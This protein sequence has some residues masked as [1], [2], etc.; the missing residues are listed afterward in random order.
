[1][2]RLTNAGE[3]ERKWE[4]LLSKLPSAMAT[5]EL[6]T[7]DKHLYLLGGEGSIKC[8]RMQ[9]CG[10]YKG[11]WKHLSDLEHDFESSASTGGAVFTNNDVVVFTLTHIMILE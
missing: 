3:E 10:E 2:F 4:L 1:M 9:N 7:G 6:L 8:G 11:P 5:P